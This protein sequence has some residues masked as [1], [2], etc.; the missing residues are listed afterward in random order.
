MPHSKNLGCC[1]IVMNHD[2][3]VLAL[4]FDEKRVACFSGQAFPRHTEKHQRK[5]QK[6]PDQRIKVYL[7]VPLDKFG[8]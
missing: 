3:C 4:A 8:F 1:G 6:C 5:L 7:L 2:A